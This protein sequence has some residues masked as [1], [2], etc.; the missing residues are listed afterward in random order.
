MVQ[1]VGIGA[2]GFL[3][4]VSKD[5]QAV[6]GSLVVYGLSQFRDSAIVP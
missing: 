1:N 2:A 4:S 3:Q 6:K 5:G